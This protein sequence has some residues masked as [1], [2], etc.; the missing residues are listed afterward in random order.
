MAVQ[1]L[2]WQ[3][4]DLRLVRDVRVLDLV[5]VRLEDDPRAVAADGGED[6]V[7]CVVGVGGDASEGRRGDVVG[8][9]VEQLRDGQLVAGEVVVRSEGD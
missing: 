7:V 1:L 6:G 2:V 4:R 8:E 5:P 9:R 3:Q